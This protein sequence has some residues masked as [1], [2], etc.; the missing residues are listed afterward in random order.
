MKENEENS[1]TIWYGCSS[2]NISLLEKEVILNSVL[3]SL[4]KARQYFKKHYQPH[5]GI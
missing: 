2:H 3:K 1:T 5:V 4:L